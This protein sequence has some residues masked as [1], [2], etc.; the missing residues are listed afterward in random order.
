MTWGNKHGRF[1]DFRHQ[2]GQRLTRKPKVVDISARVH[3]LIDDLYSVND[4]RCVGEP[5]R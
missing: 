1:P 4:Q 5:Q 2:I 3:V